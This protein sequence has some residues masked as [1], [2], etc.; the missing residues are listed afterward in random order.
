MRSPAS[1]PYDRLPRPVSMAAKPAFGSSCTARRAWPSARQL[2][3]ISSRSATNRSVTT[4]KYWPRRSQWPP[5]Q[6]AESKSVCGRLPA[7]SEEHTSELQSLMRISYAVFCLKKKTNTTNQL[8]PTQEKHTRTNHRQYEQTQ[9][10]RT[11]DTTNNNTNID[12]I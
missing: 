8:T 4:C 7:R 3:T 10:A 6:L 12:Q 5:V 1:S 2:P 9:G 11:Q